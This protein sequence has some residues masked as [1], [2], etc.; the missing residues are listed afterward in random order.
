MLWFRQILRIHT[1]IKVLVAFKIANFFRG[2]SLYLPMAAL[3]WLFPWYRR[4]TDHLSQSECLRLALEQLGPVFVKFGQLLSTRKDLLPE[5]VAN[6]LALL[7]DKVPSFDGQQAQRMIEQA[8]Q[9]PIEQLFEHFDRE[10]LA[11]ASIAQVHA[12]RLKDGRDVVIKV[13]RP[14]IEPI[15]QQ[16]MALLDT[17]AWFVAR[18]IPD[19]RRLRP[20]EVVADYRRTLF[21]ELDLMREAA[22][23]SQLRRNF[24]DSDELYV[25]EVHWDYC[26]DNVMVMERIYGTPVGDIATLRAQ[27]VNLQKLA[28]RGVE[29]FFAQVFRD[30]FFH[31]DMHPGNIFVDH[32]DPENPK[33]IG[34][35]CGIVGSLNSDDQRYLAENFLAFFN[36]DYKKVAQLH[37]DSGWVPPETRVEE[38]ESAIR[39][40][41]EPIFEK[42][43]K[44]ISYG[45]LLVRLFQTA[46]RFEM[47]VQPQLV[48]LE[49]TLLYIEGLGRQLY[50]DLDLWKTAK[51]FLEQWMKR[52]VGPVAIWS[53]VKQQFPYWTEKFP[54]MPDLLYQALHTLAQ[55]SAPVS[56]PPAAR[57]VAD[58]AVKSYLSA[59]SGTLLLVTG[60]VVWHTSL[61]DY[62][63]VWAGMSG[64][65]GVL[66]LIAGWPRVSNR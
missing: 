12:A 52:Q 40:V 53:K 17:L 13:I 47:E 34:I 33:Y 31:A 20:Q 9:Q 28:E 22:N 8:L 55:Q 48:L 36:R 24:I 66:L 26:R 6:E 27:G 61:I 32:T 57:Y 51:P 46:R 65:A 1:I 4:K 37:V 2:T 62:A 15:L 56:S 11:S 44:D 14:N 25:P 19:G 54:D 58:V 16:D 45:Q 39:T 60:L 5:E 38:F 49:K 18:F 63:A 42:P 3:G 23:A 29:V 21:D 35:D 43:L 30:N 7:Q 64:V 50:P 41:C 59:L 10:P